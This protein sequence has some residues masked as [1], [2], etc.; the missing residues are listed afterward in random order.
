MKGRRE[1][2]RRAGTHPSG[3]LQQALTLFL[4]ETR[5]SQNISYL[6]GQTRPGQ[7]RLGLVNCAKEI[8]LLICAWMP[9]SWHLVN[10]NPFLLQTR[11]LFLVSLGTCWTFTVCWSPVRV[12]VGLSWVI[13]L[14]VSQDKG[15]HCSLA[16][17]STVTDAIRRQKL[18][19]L[20]LKP[21][22]IMVSNSI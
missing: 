20:L 17:H 22:C 12:W 13:Y 18:S 4:W 14:F 16:V 5:A 2:G 7:A 11:I 15:L 21:R 1:G 3:F 9:T 10:N 6:N 8:M 19:M